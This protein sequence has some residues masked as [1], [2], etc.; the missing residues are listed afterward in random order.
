MSSSQKAKLLRISFDLVVGN[1]VLLKQKG[2]HLHGNEDAGSQKNIVPSRMMDV[3]FSPQTW[4]PMRVKCT[5][6]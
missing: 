3:L 1:D 5:Q 6:N 4:L 2:T